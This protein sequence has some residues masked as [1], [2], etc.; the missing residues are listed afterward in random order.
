MRLYGANYK[1]NRLA[2]SWGG[3]FNAYIGKPPRG[4]CG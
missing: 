1:E 2:F 3:F 4:V